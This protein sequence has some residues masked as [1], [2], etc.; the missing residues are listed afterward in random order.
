ME[1]GKIKKQITNDWLKSFPNLYPYAQNKLY[2]IVGCYIVGIELIKLPRIESYRPHFVLYPLYKANVESCLHSPILMYEFYNNKG[3]QINLPYSDTSELFKSA[4]KI[5]S[6]DLKFNINEEVVI[7][8]SFNALTDYF[9]FNIKDAWYKTHS[10]KRASLLEI[11]FYAALYSG[12]I[13]HVQTI[14]SQILEER[15][16]WNMESFEMWY[17]K[18]DLW[19]QD[20]QEKVIKREA[21]LKQISINKQDKKIDK[22]KKSELLA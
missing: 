14:L 1:I 18:F 5:I 2:K 10:G 16:G 22:L 20:L 17:G 11:K 6:D 13:N 7:L 21:F 4:Q 15:K 3:L 9:L 19:F 12:D 8:S